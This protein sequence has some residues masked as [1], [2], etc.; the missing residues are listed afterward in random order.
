MIVYPAINF[1]IF[2]WIFEL[3]ELWEAQWCL[4]FNI[5]KCIGLINPKNQYSFGGES[6]RFV[7]NDRDL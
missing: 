3:L 5:E 4:K 7:D 6:L 2:R 1:L